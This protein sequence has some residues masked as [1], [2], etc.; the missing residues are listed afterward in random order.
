[1]I[2]F[3]ESPPPK[4]SAQWV[5]SRLSTEMG[6]V[7]TSKHASGELDLLY[8]KYKSQSGGYFVNTFKQIS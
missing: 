7:S 2:L 1:M 3:K 6:D 5:F 4:T 8:H